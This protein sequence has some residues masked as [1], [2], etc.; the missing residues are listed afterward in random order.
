MSMMRPECVVAFIFVIAALLVPSSVESLQ[1]RTE[2]CHMCNAVRT[3]EHRK[4]E[5]LIPVLSKHTVQIQGGK[6][7]CRHWW[8]DP[9][10]MG[11]GW[12]CSLRTVVIPL[13]VL[14]IVAAVV[15][16]LLAVRRRSNRGGDER[17]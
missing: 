11:T 5:S 15:L 6:S 12:G 16:I 17:G 8:R 7:D 1:T 4:I 2:R 14:L 9:S 13:R 10:S 3:E